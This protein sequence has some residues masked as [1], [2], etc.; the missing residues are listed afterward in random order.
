MAKLKLSNEKR[1]G[2]LHYMMHE[3]RQRRDDTEYKAALEALL[4]Q[5]NKVLRGKYPEKDMEVLRRY[6]VT[7][8]DRCLKFAV[9]DTG[10][11]LEVRL[12][13]DVTVA[14][15][16]GHAGCYSREVFPC[17]EA[18]A[19]AA[20]RYEEMTK[21]RTDAARDKEGEYRAFVYAC[22]YLE[23]VEAIVALPERLRASL[24]ATP[25]ALVAVNED[26]L[27]SI[28]QDFAKAA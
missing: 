19:A 23:D 16:P 7:R 25:N 20:D 12:P 22:R 21:Q 27:A 5:I 14:D 15:I 26:T 28:R 13:G 24:G 10:R 9:L 8:V 3:Y 17:E 18:L 4:A 1:D 11:V 6:G 2:I